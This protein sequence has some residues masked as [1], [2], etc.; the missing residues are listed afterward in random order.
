[1]SANRFPRLCDAERR[2][3]SWNVTGGSGKAAYDGAGRRVAHQTTSGI[4]ST[5][6]YDVGGLE[7]VDGASGAVTR[8]RPAHLSPR[9][10]AYGPAPY[11]SR[12]VAACLMAARCGPRH[13]DAG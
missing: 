8:S 2:L 12:I 4:T 9:R 6:T 3:V 11:L 5:T 7:E 13:I 10:R 1:M